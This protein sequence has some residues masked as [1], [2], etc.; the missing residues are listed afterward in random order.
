[1][2]RALVLAAVL[3]SAPA[4][5]APLE[6]TSVAPGV[7]KATAGSP[8]DL[9]LLTAAGARPDA[10]G[11]SRLQRGEFPFPSGAIEATTD[12][13]HVAL[14]FPL[15]LDEDVYGLG[16]DF[17]SMRRTGSTFLLHEDHWG[18][19]PAART[20]LCPSTSRQGLRRVRGSVA[21]HHRERRRRRATRRRLETAGDRS[22]DTR[23]RTWA[24]MPRSDAVEMLRARRRRRRLCLRRTDDDGRRP[25]LQLVQRRRCAATEVGLGFM[26]RTPLAY[27]AAQVLDEVAEFRSRGIPLD[28]IGLEPGWHDHA[29]PTSFEWDR[30]AFPN[31]AGFLTKLEALHVRANLWFNPTCR[32]PLPSMRSSCPLQVRIWY[33]TASS[34]ITRCRPHGR[35]SPITCDQ[36]SSGTAAGALGGFKIDE[37]D[38]FDFWMWP[39]VATFPS[40]HDGEQLRQTYGLSLQRTSW[41]S[42]AA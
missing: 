10:P 42:I 29:Y 40:G 3:I 9:T 11:L 12:R 41:T 14:R 6:F 34:P 24:A 16:V 23:R 26:T 32:R 36:R 13:G 25:P 5:A 7:W 1:M 17:K 21:L 4:V 30:R 2:I 38:G 39:D 18:G 28:M 22:H 37:V 20:R 33:G 31:P 15:A 8:E 27:T 35:S 19:C